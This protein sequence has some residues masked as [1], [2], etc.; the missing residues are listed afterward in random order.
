MFASVP[1]LIRTKTVRTLFIGLESCKH[2]E[3]PAWKLSFVSR[4]LM[5]LNKCSRDR[6]KITMTHRRSTGNERLKAL[7]QDVYIDRSFAFQPIFSTGRLDST[8][9]HLVS[10]LFFLVC[11]CP[12]FCHSPKQVLIYDWQRGS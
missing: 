1:S 5:L 4:N 3:L 9:N 12:C 8:I 10:L 6:N 7:K 2:S 11:V